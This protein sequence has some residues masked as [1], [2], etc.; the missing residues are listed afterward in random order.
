M[1]ILIVCD[2]LFKYGAQQ[3]RALA[4]SDHDVAMLCR[5]HALEFG[6]ADTERD[7]CVESL[8]REGIQMLA[9]PG[10]VR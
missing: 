2:F 8:E 10:R 5:S 3:A 4:Q 9:V 1:R 7:Q 6:G